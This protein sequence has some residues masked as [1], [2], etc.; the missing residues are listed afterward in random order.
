MKQSSD[1]TTTLG[2]FHMARG[3][4]MLYIIFGHS[5]T[6]FFDK[7][8]SLDDPTLFA[9]AGSVIG[10]GIIAMFFLSSGYGVRMVSP[11]NTLCRQARNLLVPY[12]L[13]ATAIV[14]S[15]LLLSF[16]RARPFSEN[17]GELIPTFLFGLNA[18]GGGTFFGMAVD[19]VGG[20]WFLLALFGGN[21]L[22]SLIARIKR[23]KTRTI[24]YVLCPMLGLLLFRLSAV[25]C[26]CFAQMLLCVG[27]LRAGILLSERRL[28]SKRLPWYVHPPMLAVLLLSL[29]RGYV[30]MAD[31][32]FSRGAVD[33]LATYII[34]FYLLRGYTALLS[35]LSDRAYERLEPIAFIGRYSMPILCLHVFEKCIFPWYRLET[36]AP[37]VPLLSAC[38]CFAARMLL[39]CFLF[40]AMLWLRRIHRRARRKQHT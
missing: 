31:G 8:A 35:R 26:F 23:A 27:Y 20:F 36:V 33:L 29:A 30:N 22:L 11:G 28:L 7:S 24:L 14:L 5:L 25:W 9:G 6:P 39:I 10:G 37:G 2:F 18:E 17:G 34:G 3:L 38:I 15:K 1:A 4:G 13:T 21:L 12:F 40:A 19:S 32:T 16:V